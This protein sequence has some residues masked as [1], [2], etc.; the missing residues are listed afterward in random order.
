[1][2]PNLLSKPEFRVIAAG[3]F[4]ATCLELMAEVLENRTLTLIITKRGKPVAQMTAPPDGL[5]LSGPVVEL[6]SA[7]RPADLSSL[8]ASAAV[9]KPRKKK[10]KDKKKHK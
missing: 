8:Q 4:K 1:M 5:K 7:I 6:D 10:R 9:E 2:K 3:K